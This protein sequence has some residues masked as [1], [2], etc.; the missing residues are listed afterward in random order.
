MS[1][2][3]RTLAALSLPLALGLGVALAADQPT[4]AA[5]FAPCSD[6]HDTL[7]PAFLTNPH[8]TAS[9]ALVGKAICESCHGDGTKH[10]EEGGDTS[11]I[12]VPRGATGAKVCLSCHQDRPGFDHTATG[13][14]ASAS[15]NCTDCHSVHAAV[16]TPLL[17]SKASTLCVSCHLE[18]KMQFGKPYAHR[19]GRGG[20]ECTSCHNPHGGPGVD[21]S[22]KLTMAGEIPCLSC[23][24]ETQ[25]PFVFTHVTGIAGNC[26]SCHEPHGSNNARMLTRSQVDQ[27]CLE[28]HTTLPT[29][30][31]GPQPPS[32]HD[33][34]SARYT[35]CTVCHVAIHGSNS[36]PMLFR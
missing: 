34:R 35:N 21:K 6:C 5:A 19:I 13:F 7:V 16:T 15:V 30:L 29:G 25:G 27:L 31:L 12:K 11:F 32:I 17:R 33:L 28:C 8:A 22:L 18:Q 23:H 2:W 36:S 9:T 1:T 4:G 26:L 3:L 24:P 14:H 20:I 10:A